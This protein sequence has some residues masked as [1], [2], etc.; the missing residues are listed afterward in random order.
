MHRDGNNMLIKVVAGPY[1]QWPL[2]WYLKD[3]TRVG[4]WLSPEQSGGFD[5]VPVIVASQENAAELEKT[6]GD[7]YQSEYYG[8]RPNALLT[9]FI[10]RTLW[11]QYL[12]RR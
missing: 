5:G 1:E 4:Y 11:D 6:L 10:E 2:P 12:S 9:L 7:G 3:M 8:L